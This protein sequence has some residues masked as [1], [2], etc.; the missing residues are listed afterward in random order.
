MG[1][2]VSSHE[3]VEPGKTLIAD[4]ASAGEL[5]HAPRR[6]RLLAG[7]SSVCVR[8]PGGRLIWLETDRLSAF[9]DVDGQVRIVHH[10]DETTLVPRDTGA[11]ARALASLDAFRA[12]IDARGESAPVPTEPYLGRPST[13]LALSTE[14]GRSTA[15]TRDLETGIILFARGRSLQGEFELQVRSVEIRETTADEFAPV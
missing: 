3:N 11:E 2:T 1:S 7:A 12:W 10:E 15:I 5:M 8:D 4:V 9:T 6:L 13:G 14:D